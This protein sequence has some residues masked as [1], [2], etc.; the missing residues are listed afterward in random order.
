MNDHEIESG[1]RSLTLVE[2]DLGFDPD[3]V[4]TRAAKLQRTRRATFIAL[5]GAA[6]VV[7][8]TAAAIAVFRGGGATAVPVT[9]ANTPPTTV[10]WTPSPTAQPP[11]D[12]T[13]QVARINGHMD[14]VFPSV[15]PGATDVQNASGQQYTQLDSMT[16]TK[17]FQD[18]NGSASFNLTVNGGYS[19]KYL[20]RLPDDECFDGCVRRPQPDGS[21]VI[22]RT[23]KTDGRRPGDQTAV[24]YRR[25]GTS[26]NIIQTNFAATSTG[27]VQPG[28][29]PFPLNEQQ[30]IALLTDPAFTLT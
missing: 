22:I 8:V 21:L 14:A 24:H 9:E 26:V 5:G 10:P 13:A 20:V 2:P 12:E 3:E 11:F 19:S 7:V 23:G 16:L 18:A 30:L 17:R 6:V 28:V 15:V 1:L 27:S 25:D 29:R 4:V